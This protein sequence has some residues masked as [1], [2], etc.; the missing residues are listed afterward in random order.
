MQRDLRFDGRRM[1]D[2]Q[3]LGL[4]AGRSFD[5]SSFEGPLRKAI[6]VLKFQ[7]Q[8]EVGRKCGCRLV[9]N[10]QF[11]GFVRKL[12]WLVPVPLHSARQRERGY[13]QS[14][15][16]ARGVNDVLD[17]LLARGFD[18]TKGTDTATGEP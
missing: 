17:L 18:Q 6:H 16:I 13:N 2:L 10:P 11:H 5:L 7:H 14:Y 8:T 12:D 1:R 9:H 15:R 3:R 4:G